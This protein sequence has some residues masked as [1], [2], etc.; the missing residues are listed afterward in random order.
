MS[1]IKRG[2]KIKMEMLF[3]IVLFDIGVIIQ[4][5]I[6]FVEKNNKKLVALQLLGMVVVMCILT[7]IGI[8]ASIG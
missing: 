3:W 7:G 2:I 6:V 1:Y 8:F 5:F 4:L